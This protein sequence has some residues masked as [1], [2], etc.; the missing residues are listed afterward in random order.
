MKVSLSNGASASQSRQIK[1]QFATPGDSLSYELG[2]AVQ[3]LPPLYTR[4]L[5]G[6]IC[7][8]TLSAIAWA[9][10]SQVEEVAVA[11]GK[12]I[13]STEVRPVRSLS[14][15]NVSST[16]VKAGDLVKKDDVL[17]EID[18]GASET[19]VDSLE[20]EANKIREEISRLETESGG[21]INGATPEQRRLLDAR[22]QELQSKQAAAQAD[23]GRQQASIQEA[24]SRLSRFQENL[25]GAR[26]TVENEQAAKVQAE[27][28]L[29]ISEEIYSKL[30]TLKNEGAVP[31]QQILQAEQAVAQATQQVIA[32][33]G[34]INEA[35]QQI[36]S[37]EKEIDAQGDRVT[38]AQQAFQGATST[39]QSIAPQRTGEV[40]TQLT[41]R[42]SELSKKQ[43]EID[44]AKQQKKERSSLKAAFDGQVYNVK[45]TQGPVQQGEEL[46]SILPMGEEIIMDVKVM[47]QDVGF[48]KTGMVAKVK[49]AS[50]PYQEFGVVEGEVLQISPDA[51]VEKDAQGREMGPVFPA[52]V[53]LKKSKIQTRDRIVDLTP[54]M[55]GTA[56]IV[57]RKKSILSFVLDPINKKFSEALSV[58]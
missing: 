47:N 52:K 31:N 45:V 51:I 11:Q 58:R 24:E 29:A 1:Q 50:F 21:S 43:G 40:L 38:Q 6:G 46:L 28:S 3:E 22:Q 5:S 25:I 15:G 2:K 9:H 10:F 18:P 32:A 12:L 57:T 41:Q 37:L 54:G 20:K 33:S 27:R 36:V 44:V 14:V 56:D 8:M 19:S 34:R 30:A 42:R 35:E 48:I 39:A 16:K 53:R 23:A 13:P 26:I 7:V 17:V 49:L 55:A 4:V